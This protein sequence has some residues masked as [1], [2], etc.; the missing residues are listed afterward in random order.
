M[1]D[2]RTMPKRFPSGDQAL[3]EFMA[4]LTGMPLSRP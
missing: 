3:V 4:T 1:S 2:P